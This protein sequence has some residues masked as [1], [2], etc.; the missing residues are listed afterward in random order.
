MMQKIAFCLVSILLSCQ[1]LFAQQTPLITGSFSN[2]SFDEFVKD[3]E[4]QTHLH[5]YY[6]RHQMDS[7]RISTT[8]NNEPV[9]QVLK[10]V[11]EGT[12]FFF[13]VYDNSILITKDRKLYA[14]LPPN[15]FNQRTEEKETGEVIDLSAYENKTK[16]KK[17]EEIVFKIGKPTSKL[18]GKATLTGIVKDI[19]SGEAIVSASVV[20]QSSST[21]A[22]TDPFGRYILTLS[23]GKHILKVKSLGMKITTR[24]VQLYSDGNLDIELEEEIT[25]L[26]EVSIQSDREAN[27]QGLQMGVQKL[28]IKM[29]KQIP[30]GLGE[31]DILKVITTLP[32]VQTVG[33]GTLGLNV[34]GGATS[35]NL[36]LFN[37]ALIY[38]PSHFF[39]FF[40][41]FNPDVVKSVELYKSGMTADYGGRLSSVLD[42]RSR[43]G[44]L[45]KISGSG[46]ISPV[47]ARFTLEG[48]LVKGKTSFLIG[49]RSTYSDWLMKQINT[50]SLQ[51]SEASFY[52]ITGNIS[53]KINNNNSI[54]IS[55]YTS[56]DRFK[57]NSDTSY[58]YGNQNAS[59]KWT[60][61]F[62][63][64]LFGSIVGGF[65]QYRYA[66]LG[67]ENKVNAF[68]MNFS[69]LQLNAKAD[70]NYTL[71]SKHSITAGASLLQYLLS[72]GNL[73]PSGTK[74]LIV[75]NV[76]EQE[77][78]R[79]SAVY[80]GDNFDF[81]PS[82]SFYFGV[83]YS[84]YQYLG[85]KDVYQYAAGQPRQV[86]SITDTIQY[87][88][89]ETIAH[90]GGLEPRFSA[91]Y[92]IS[93]NSSVKFS[94][95]RMRQYIQ[96]L[97]NTTA[98][99]P[100]DIWK[101]SDSYIKPQI[102]DQFSIGFYK[103]L[104]RNLIE[105]SIEAY[106]KTIQNT[107]D[108]KGGA[109]LLMNHH[110]E[111]DVLNANGK[112]YGVEFFI[113]KS[114]GKI[115]GWVSYTYSRSFLQTVG[116]NSSETVNQGKY[117]P[118]SYDKPH[119]FNFIGNYKFS[120]RFNFSLNTI[121]STGRPITL[122]TGKYNLDGS[123]RVFYS[124]RNQYRIPDYFRVDVSINVDGNHKIKKLAHSSWTF[125]IYN[126][127][128][129][130]NAYSVY[131]V[132]QNGVINGYQLSIFAQPIPTVTYNFRF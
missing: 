112:A 55:G 110:I 105:T 14:I 65:S 91:R 109:V 108:Y 78:A 37:D 94:Y 92:S 83:R 26:K 45:K 64:K 85:A 32:G 9:S 8:F 57:L 4:L 115:N 96:M 104:K 39:G 98:V 97:S 102:G 95:N 126:L 87:G 73:Q 81:S 52:D 3:V 127:L 93:E 17:N 5:F 46:G 68:S 77:H 28:D 70:F 58:Q 31:T 34:R 22:M 53:H 76:L 56:A 42:I 30:L 100:T 48:P 84:H 13:S 120:R 107:V 27:V 61:V 1:A 43:E 123:G 122:P 99:T 20:D 116:L 79:E 35:Q 59:A 11:F 33:E 101:L 29:M 2:T 47:A 50:K 71:N 38:N 23:K 117:Y 40:S 36:I 7:L 111:T 24:Q 67:N 6:D 113:R 60:H 41:T 131:F 75:P 118:S 16:P 10:T 69:V 114:T 19:Q 103:N 119:A 62:N 130:H 63:P 25:P 12:N 90:Y 88:S 82:L 129:R 128:G 132:S 66:I 89:G 121:Y 80:V 72:P 51:N 15:F 124:D 49:A 54:V 86:T 21:G 106:W 18:E 44:S 125:A 74:S